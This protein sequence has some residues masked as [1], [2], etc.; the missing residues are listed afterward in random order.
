MVSIQ[1]RGW[2]PQAGKAVGRK[3][4]EEIWE[5]V[6][7]MPRWELGEAPDMLAEPHVPTP[8]PFILAPGVSKWP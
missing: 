6:E 3:G 4:S 7:S 2:G 1:N 8:V 5:D